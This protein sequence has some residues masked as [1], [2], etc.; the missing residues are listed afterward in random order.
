MFVPLFL[1]YTPPGQIC[2]SFFQHRNCLFSRVGF[3]ADFFSGTCP[4]PPFLTDMTTKTPNS[5]ITKR[6]HPF[7]GVWQ[8][9]RQPHDFNHCS[10]VPSPFFVRCDNE[11]PNPMILIIVPLFHALLPLYYFIFYKKP[12]PTRENNQF[13][14]WSQNYTKMA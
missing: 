2:F 1:I 4:E 6:K 14:C 10:S 12:R 11:R 9:T 8:R 5:M 7:F 3:S 13:L